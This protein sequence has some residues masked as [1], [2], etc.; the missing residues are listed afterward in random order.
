MNGSI[1]AAA[2]RT[3]GNNQ[4]NPWPNR[5]L[6]TQSLPNQNAISNR[7]TNPTAHIPSLL[8]I[9]VPHPSEIRIMPDNSNQLENTNMMD[10]AKRKGLPAWIR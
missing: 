7:P 2:H 9:S 8:K 4:W 3:T 5:D 6:L 10:A 1:K